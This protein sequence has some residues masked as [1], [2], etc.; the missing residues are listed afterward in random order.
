LYWLVYR[1]ESHWRFL[2][3]HPSK[4]KGDR[5]EREVIALFKQAGLEAKRIDARVGQFGADASHD[6]DVYKPGRD[7][8]L[9]GEV[10][11]RKSFPKWLTGWLADNDWLA[12]RG[13]REEPIFILP[14]RVMIEL[15]GGKHD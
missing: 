13:D 15:L 4:I 10:K 12:L 7:A 6:V 14:Q 1:L 3:A 2:V 5:I 9:C 11:A 8:P